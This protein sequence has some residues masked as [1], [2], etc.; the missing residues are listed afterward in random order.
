MIRLKRSAETDRCTQLLRK[1]RSVWKRFLPRL[2]SSGSVS[3]QGF[4]GWFAQNEL[5]FTPLALF[6]AAV[7]RCWCAWGEGCCDL[8]GETGLDGPDDDAS[9]WAVP[10]GTGLSRVIQ[11][12]IEANCIFYSKMCGSGNHRLIWGPKFW[13]LAIFPRTLSCCCLWWF[14]CHPVW[15]NIWHQNNH[16]S[17]Y[18]ALLRLRKSVFQLQNPLVSSQHQQ[19]CD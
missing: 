1:T 9:S 12:G 10:I 8:S 19:W 14:V 6:I 4:S 17:F 2:K 5:S 13:E 16:W 7:R 11:R 15:L 18:S 3:V